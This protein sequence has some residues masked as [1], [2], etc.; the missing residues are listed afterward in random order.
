MA[1]RLFPSEVDAPFRKMI[2][3]QIKNTNPDVYKMSLIK[4][5]LLNLD[6]QLNKI[7][8][9]CLMITGAQEIQR[10]CL[11]RKPHWQRRYTIANRSLLLT[12]DMQ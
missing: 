8:T 12:Q 1:K 2:V 4:I 7:T 5:G 10:Y 9:P 6:R 3:D 11:L